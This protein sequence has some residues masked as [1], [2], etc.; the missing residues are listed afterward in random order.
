MIYISSDHGG[1]KLKNIL[2][3]TLAELGYQV[4][5]LGPTTLDLNDDYPIYVN[6][7][8]LALKKD[9]EGRGIVLCR[10]G[11]GVCI[12]ANKYN[13]IR[14]ALS[15]DP[16]H[17]AS[18]ITDD[19]TNV[20][21]L[22]ADYITPQQAAEIVGTWLNTKYTG[23]LRHKRRLDEVKSFTSKLTDK[24]PESLQTQ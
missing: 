10:N 24:L 2:T 1:F 23:E 7:L 15:F 18:T 13:H 12:M 19:N 4:T 8:A 11:V 20:L 9:T 21:A 5:D 17:A 22:P 14:C 6:K 3:K 16:A